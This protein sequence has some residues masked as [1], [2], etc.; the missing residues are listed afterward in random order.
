MMRSAGL[1][2]GSPSTNAFPAC[3]NAAVGLVWGGRVMEGMFHYRAF[4]INI[5][6]LSISIPLSA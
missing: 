3:I 1:L 6:L 2:S 4:H 5:F